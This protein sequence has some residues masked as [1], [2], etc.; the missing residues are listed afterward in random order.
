MQITYSRQGPDREEDLRKTIVKCR[1]DV[2]IVRKVISLGKGITVKNNKIHRTS[3][4][5]NGKEYFKKKEFG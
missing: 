5:K 3:N 2:A 1:R 4:G